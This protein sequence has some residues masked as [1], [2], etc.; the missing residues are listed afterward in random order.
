MALSQDIIRQRVFSNTLFDEKETSRI[1]NKYF[2]HKSRLLRTLLERYDLGQKRVLEIGSAYGFDLIHFGA[3]SVGL[4]VRET[5]RKFGASI[6]LD[7]REANVEA[8][9]PT[10]EQP[11]EAV[12][13]SNLVEHLVAPHL[14]LLR[15]HRLLTPNGLIC[16]RVPITPH[17]WVFVLYKLAG[18]AHGFDQLEHVNFF[19]PL[20][21][22]WTVERAGYRVLGQ[23][24]P[25]LATLPWLD[26]VAPL[27]AP[28]L[29]ST[30]VVAE[31][32]ADF[33]YPRERM[34]MF[35]PPYA[36]E[37]LPYYIE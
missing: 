12:Y 33:K 24:S 11:F 17:P 23:H 6:G 2:V 15:L 37:I 27:I 25:I 31:K 36:P 22:R 9:L 5:Y 14:F 1:Y 10:F 13:C 20:T 30:L 32:I 8:D 21:F 4:D 7:I 19:T 28:L 16:I 29:P 34:A 35:N 26:P 3:G 18:K